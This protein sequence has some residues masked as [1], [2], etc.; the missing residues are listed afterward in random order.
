MC[1]INPFRAEVLYG[2]SH[3][4]PFAVATVLIKRA[5]RVQIPLSNVEKL[6]TTRDSRAGSVRVRPRG[7]ACAIQ[8]RFGRS[9]EQTRMNYI[10]TCRPSDAQ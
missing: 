4:Y 2:C 1:A 5:E 9:V 8:R 6:S 7:V 10:V 3:A